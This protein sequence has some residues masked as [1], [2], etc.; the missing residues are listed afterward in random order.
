MS[1]RNEAYARAMLEVAKGDGRLADVEDEL[2]RFARTV[3]GNDDLRSAL[4]DESL[5]LT[6]RVGVIEDILGGGGALSTTTALAVMIVA[7]GRASDLSLIVDRFVALAAGEREQEIA[8]V[9]TAVPL[10]DEQRTRLASALAAST[11]KKIELKEVTD[12]NV[13]G[14]VY[15]RI[16]D[17][18]I[19]GTVRHRIDQLK[20]FI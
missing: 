8:E 6:R 5:P 19:D 1:D 3:E 20:E 11:R 17:R 9:R 2:Y 18:V 4:V 15:V 12:P 13:V 7:G 14:G 10:T 16:G